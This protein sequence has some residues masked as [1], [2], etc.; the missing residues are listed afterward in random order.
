MKASVFFFVAAA[1]CSTSYAQQP[2]FISACHYKVDGTQY[3]DIKDAVPGTAISFYSEMHGGELVK[4]A[5]ADASGK[6]SVVAEAKFA[7]AFVLNTGTKNAEGVKGSGKVFF[8][9]AEEFSLSDIEL[10]ATGN[11]VNLSWSASTDPAKE[12]SFEILK[13][14]N[15]ADYFSVADIK[16]YGG[17]AV[18]PYAFNEEKSLAGNIYKIKVKNAQEGVRYTSYPLSLLHGELHVY[19]TVTSGNINIDL[20]YDGESQYAISNTLGQPIM[21]G[22]LGKGHHNIQLGELAAGIYLVNV[23]SGAKTYS[24]KI[25]KE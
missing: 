20:N 7:P 2:K 18:T 13:S 21:S 11:K 4:E 19:P 3:Y 9:E 1:I 8:M 15:G 14:Y 22:I 25:V 24:E 10:K 12:I 23:H 6:F 5:V 16:A 17:A